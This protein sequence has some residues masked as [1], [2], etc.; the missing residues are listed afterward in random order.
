LLNGLLNGLLWNVVALFRD[1]T[2]PLI[3]L[4]S[5]TRLL[6][7]RE[8]RRVLRGVLEPMRA[9]M[10]LTRSLRALSCRGRMLKVEAFKRGSEVLNRVLNSS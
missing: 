8:F 9:L 2:R 6:R 1:L 3:S 4:K 7:L 5:L 10:G